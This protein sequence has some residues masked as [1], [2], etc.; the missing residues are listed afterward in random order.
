MLPGSSLTVVLRYS[1]CLHPASNKEELCGRDVDGAGIKSHP[2]QSGAD[3]PPGGSCG[4]EGGR[5]GVE[6]SKE[7]E[8]GGQDRVGR[9][10]SEGVQVR[11]VSPGGIRKI[12]CKAGI[13][14]LA[15]TSQD[16]TVRSG[17]GRRGKGK[18]VCHL[19]SGREGR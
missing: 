17:S 1:P 16:Q 18:G 2:W 9:V 14:V 12:K 8:A 4:E 7:I 3:L 15:S 11:V 19:V 5:R 13:V 6:A 10:V